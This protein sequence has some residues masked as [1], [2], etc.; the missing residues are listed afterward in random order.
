MPV[1][2]KSRE[3]LIFLGVKSFFGRKENFV[4]TASL[5][6]SWKI[7]TPLLKTFDDETENIH[8]PITYTIGG[9]EVYQAVQNKN[10]R[11]EKV[12]DEL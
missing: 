8:T 3:I 12:V 2:K 7:W 1:K 9:K 10:W 6:Q 11:S 5:L 4:A